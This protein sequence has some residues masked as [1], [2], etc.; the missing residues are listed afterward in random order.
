MTVSSADDGTVLGLATEAYLYGFPL[1]FDLEQ[2]RRFVTAGIGATGPAPYNEIAHA[3]A[4]AGPQDTFVSINNDTVYS[5]AQLDLGV[6]PL[7]LH[8]PDTGGRYYVLQFVDAW[9]NNFAYVG[10]RATGTATGDYLLVPPG[11]SGD[12]PTGVTVIRVPTRVASIV[13]RWACDGDA[14]LPAVHALQ[15]AVGLE[16]IDPDAKPAGVP[17]PDPSVPDDLVFWEKLR[18]W[19][20]EFPPPPRDRSLQDRLAPT[21]I[22]G[23]GP[24]PFLRADPD[25]ADALR[26]GRAAGEA[27]LKQ[28]M[29]AGGTS[30]EVN[31][32]KLT[33]HVFDYNLDYFEVGALDDPRFKIA[34]PQERITERAAAAMA[35]LWG[36]HAYEAV[37]IMTYHDDRGGS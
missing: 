31:G 21:G 19:S 3:R 37:Y 25:L 17:D 11:W 26:H 32:W 15:D 7:R 4:L 16:Q 20:Q 23:S 14:D 27:A 6:G 10:H 8:V 33:L 13:G 5:M 1:V 2:V 9:T 22:T 18:L 36:N 28:A 29:T 30:P 35:G 24:S 12:A 34:D